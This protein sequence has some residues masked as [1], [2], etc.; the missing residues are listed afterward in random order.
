VQDEAAFNFNDS[1]FWAIDQSE[2]AEFELDL[3]QT[4]LR[5][6]LVKN[7]E[8][9]F[10]DA[11]KERAELYLTKDLLPALM[12][13]YSPS[14]LAQN[15]SS[16]VIPFVIDFMTKRFQA[17]NRTMFV[18]KYLQ[19][20]AESQ[21]KEIVGIEGY[22][23]QVKALIGDLNDLE[24][25]GFTETILKGLEKDELSSNMV[26]YLGSTQIM[27]DAYHNHQ[28]DEICTLV[29]AS[30]EM[31]NQFIKNLY[32]RIFYDRNELMFDRTIE[33]VKEGATFIGVGA[34]H[35][36]GS[37]GLIQQ[38]KDAGFSVRPIDT[39]T[40][41]FATDFKWETYEAGNFSVD[42]MEGATLNET[43]SSNRDFYFMPYL[44]LDEEEALFTTRGLVSFKV[45]VNTSET[46]QQNYNKT[47]LDFLESV[48]DD[49]IAV[50]PAYDSD[51]AAV[52][53]NEVFESAAEQDIVVIEKDVEYD[54]IESVEVPDAPEVE[55]PMVDVPVQGYDV[56]L[57]E[58]EYRELNEDDIYEQWSVTDI[59]A[60]QEGNQDLAAFLAEQIVYPTEALEEGVEGTVMLMFVV[61]KEGSV[62]DI[63]PL[64]R[65]GYGLEEEAMRVVE[66][67]SGMWTPARLRD[68][69]VNMRFRLPVRF[70]MFDDL[71]TTDD[72]SEES[73]EIVEDAV[74]VEQPVVE[75]PINEG[76]DDEE[77][78]YYIPQETQDDVEI[79]D[80]EPVKR[81]HKI[82]LSNEQEA[83]L[84]DFG[85]SLK[86]K[87]KAIADISKERFGGFNY[88]ND[89]SEIVIDGITCS[90]I[91]RKGMMATSKRV[92][93]ITEDATYYIEAKG[94]PA[95]IKSDEIDHFFKS[96]R[97][98]E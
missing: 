34:G 93:Y 8:S 67:T 74:E 90:M 3:N 47:V 89:T 11:F 50:T 23:E 96:F 27:I 44:N 82:E 84:E 20:Y 18:D 26:N 9:H 78:E 58:E 97:L 15:I 52:P 63:S 88:G 54:M 69:P 35:L 43:Y 55:Q 29:S 64:S 60:F 48:E 36:C 30:T 94:D 98:N 87:T 28:L 92:A 80:I 65:K 45:E 37:N 42:I 59:A 57:D 77:T 79:E 2:K 21:G 14:E 85:D 62:T 76:L 70:T 16:K 61:D 38:Y 31:E 73:I 7:M 12:E 75:I 1:V 53:S 33:D 83:W 32:K 24:F 41:D 66:L 10:D 40:K 19:E 56:V 46:S 22:D 4:V 51:A 86:V 5:N 13:R 25:D 81:K 72:D 39:K 95:L 91:T 6:E 49:A 17:D 71:E 68:K